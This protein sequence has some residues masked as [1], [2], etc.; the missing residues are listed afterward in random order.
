MSEY[1]T[2]PRVYHL[3]INHLITFGGHGGDTKKG[4]DLCAHALKAMR[5]DFGS[6]RA[7]RELMHMI[8]ISGQFPVK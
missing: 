6:E 5:R 3:A 2:Y 1:N 8:F 4:R 7:R